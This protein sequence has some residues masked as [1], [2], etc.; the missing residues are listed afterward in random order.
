MSLLAFATA[1]QQGG[2]PSGQLVSTFIMFGSIILI[3]YF[4]MIRPQQKRQKEMKAMLDSMKTGDNVVTS[5]G[6][7]GKIAE[8]D[9]DDN[10]VTLI[11]SENNTRVKFD[12]A[13]IAV[14]LKK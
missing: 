2:D 4:M 3:F 7:H 1:P 9:E 5:S 8:I 12:K 13:S 10:T 6:M 11:V 14:V